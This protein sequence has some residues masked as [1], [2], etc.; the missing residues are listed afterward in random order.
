[1]SMPMM[2]LTRND[3]QFGQEGQRRWRFRYRLVLAERNDDPLWPIR[4]AHHFGVS[5][6]LVV[7][8]EA[9]ALPELAGLEVDFDGGPVTALKLSEDG[10]RLILRLWNV[11]DRPVDGTVRLLDGFVR[12]Q[13]CDA[14][15]RPL[16]D[17]PLAERRTPFTANAYDIITIALCRA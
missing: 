5:P 16:S 1:M 8:E 4:E 7:P 11:L 13:R 12:A 17:L 14:L 6:Y 10:Q 3:W 15:E 9:P 2:N